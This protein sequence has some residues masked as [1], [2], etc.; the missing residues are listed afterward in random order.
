[1]R[2]GALHRNGRYDA[3]AVVHDD[4]VILGDEIKVPAPFR[5][6]FDEC[7]RN[8]HHAYAGGHDCPD[9]QGEIDPIHPG[10]ITPGEHCLL[11]S[12]AL[13]GRERHA[14]GGRSGLQLAG[15]GQPQL[16]S[17]LGLGRLS[18]ALLR[19]GLLSLPLL[20]LGLLSLPL[21]RLRLRGSSLLRL[22]SL[23]LRRVAVPALVLAARLLVSRTGWLCAGRIG[24]L[25]LIPL[26]LRAWLFRAGL[27]RALAGALLM[28]GPTGL[29]GC[30]VRAG[31][32]IS[33][34]LTLL[35]LLAL[36]LR[37]LPSSLIALCSA[38]ATLLGLALPALLLRSLL[39]LATATLRGF[40]VILSGRVA[41]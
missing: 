28:F 23:P 24:L 30:L 11:D 37:G 19:L 17:L 36:W 13:L 39:R 8:L 22:R 7:V 9:T 41:C 6:N 3:V 21:L 18:L 35:S 29:S 12:R 2:A 16:A 31:L 33:V 10:Y 32:S 25:S 4:D 38:F 40:A 26:A 5:M 34:A 14:A 27:F 15:L 20:R 1:M